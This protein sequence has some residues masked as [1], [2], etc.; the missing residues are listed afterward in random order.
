MVTLS[1]CSR[2]EDKETVGSH[3]GCGGYWF[4]E[5]RSSGGGKCQW[6]GV[7]GWADL[8]SCHFVRKLCHVGVPWPPRNQSHKLLLAADSPKPQALHVLTASSTPLLN[9]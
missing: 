3:E 2:E 1:L 7:E 6:W 9:I 5:K 4:L 8:I